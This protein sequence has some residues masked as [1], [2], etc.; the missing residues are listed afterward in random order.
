[1][2]YTIYINTNT[3][4]TTLEVGEVDSVS[5]TLDLVGKNVNNYGEYI[6]NNLVKLLTNSAAPSDYEPRSPQ[7]GQLWYDNQEKR[8]KVYNGSYFEPVYSTTVDGVEPL[9]TST[10][11]FWFDSDASQLRIWDGNEYQLVGPATDATLGKFGIEPPP[12]NLHDA[13]SSMKYNAGVL[14]SYGSYFGILSTASF[15]L[16]PSTSSVFIN[17]STVIPVA[18]G[19]TIFNNLEVRGDITQNNIRLQ[20]QPFKYISAYYDTTRFGTIS[21]TGSTSTNRTR[22]DAANRAIANT[23]E[24]MFP[25]MATPVDSEA[26]VSCDF[27][28]VVAFTTVTTLAGTGTT[29]ISILTSTNVQPGQLVEGSFSLQPGVFV[30]STS[31]NTVVLSSGLVNELASGS[32]LTFSTVTTTARHFRNTAGPREWSPYELY[33]TATTVNLGPRAEG[34]FSNIVV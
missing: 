11:E 1:M 34:T 13:Y 28:S 3:V 19:L 33:S 21:T 20:D 27:K 15:S 31:T 29:T 24:K 6:N 10:G 9:T 7:E 5:T 14:H 17:N 23:L 32:V 30:E 12:F 18:N 25:T 8:L 2:A 16:E 26:K 4:L 22:Y